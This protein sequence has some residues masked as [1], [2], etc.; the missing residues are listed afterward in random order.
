M[1]EVGS[2]T[3]CVAWRCPSTSLAASAGHAATSRAPATP[4]IATAGWQTEVFSRVA[5]SGRPPAAGMPVRTTRLDAPPLRF[6][7]R[8]SHGSA[9]ARQRQTRDERLTRPRRRRKMLVR[10]SGPCLGRSPPSRR[11]SCLGSTTRCSGTPASGSSGGRR[12]CLRRCLRAA[13]RSDLRSPREPRG[14]PARFCLCLTDRDVAWNDVL[15]RNG[16]RVI[17][18]AG[19]QR[20]WCQGRHGEFSEVV[21]AL[22]SGSV[23]RCHMVAPSGRAAG[24]VSR[25]L[26]AARLSGAHVTLLRDGVGGIDESPQV[27]RELRRREL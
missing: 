16:L 1:R 7:P 20:T 19:G 17:G 9:G 6:S 22:S 25:A 15:I 10:G 4:P 14:A 12:R 24:E 3:R 21:T 8:A 27:A 11:M 18:G 23:W 13:R 26:R 2:S 5:K